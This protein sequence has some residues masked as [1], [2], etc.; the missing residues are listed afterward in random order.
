MN[1][2]KKTVR[3]LWIAAG[4]ALVSAGWALFQWEQLIIAR[5]GGDAVCIGGGHCTD[6]WNSPFATAIHA[7]TGMPVAAWGVV[8]GLVALVLPAVAAIRIGRRR[9][10][11]AWIG[12]T[13]LVALAGIVGAAVLLA[14]SIHVGHICTTCALTYALILGYVMLCFVSLG[15]PRVSALLSGAPLALGV[16]AAAV[17]L[18]FVPGQRT[19]RSMA[20]TGAK[21]MESLPQNGFPPGATA[22]DRE[23]QSFI[24][25][26]PV[27]A[28]QL[29]SDT[30][31]AY[32][33]S[34]VVSLPAARSVIGPQYPRLVITEWTDTLC[35]HCAQMHELLKE[36]RQRLGSDAFS[37]AGHQYPLD[38]SCNPN[39]KGIESH[40]VRCLAARVQI[41]AEGK[42]NEFEF[43][44][45]LFENQTTLDEAKLWE[46]SQAIGPRA[47]VEACAKSPETEKKLQDDI[48]WAQT[49]GIQGTPFLFIGG[50]QTLAFPPLIYALALARGVLTHPAFAALP[51]PQ[52]IPEN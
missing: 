11:D 7:R 36:I 33:A 35:G 21:A 1:D 9:S 12:G 37:L 18:L 10:V 6:V 5:R 38:P 19:P 13:F 3:T 34:P 14:A 47:E 52:P 27:E 2:S 30:L 29:L 16:G 45:S 50:R 40:P 15:L 51:P 32:T 28:K 23:L 20:E 31:G 39:L 26:L 44:G 49:H 22:D 42:P 48:A 24:S 43:Q 4:I 46:L 25:G 41:C 8:W 17:A